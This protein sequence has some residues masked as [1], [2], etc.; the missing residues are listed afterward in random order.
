[1]KFIREINIFFAGVVTGMVF[2]ASLWQNKQTQN[3]AVFSSFNDTLSESNVLYVLNKINVLC[4][5]IVLNQAKLESACFTSNLALQ[6]NNIFGLYNSSKKEY[7][8]FN[9]WV[10]SCVAYKWWVQSKYKGGN[11][12][13]FLNNLPYATDVN[14]IEKL[15]NFE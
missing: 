11:Y 9:H 13:E 7:Y 3:E 10:E 5:E 1:M 8:T 4:P 14:Y 2:V 15:K 12:Y 6:K